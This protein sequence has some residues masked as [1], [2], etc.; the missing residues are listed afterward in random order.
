MSHPTI[1]VDAMGGDH[2]PAAVVRGA[3]AAV[4][5]GHLR[6]VLVG[7]AETLAA[8]LRRE[9]GAPADALSILNAADVV[10]M[11][12]SP[13]TALRRKPEASVRVA[14]DLVARGEADALFSA[15]HTGATLLA[16][17]AA[18][19]MLSGVERPALA[20]T[21]PTRTGAAVLLDAGANPDCRPHHLVQFALMGSAY[22]R[23]ALGVARPR[24]AL[25]STGEEA[26]KGNDLIRQAHAELT[27]AGV[28]FIGNIEAQAL[29]SGD[30]DVIVCDGFTG[31]I[32][33][34]VSEGLVALIHAM[35]GADAFGRSLARLD[36]AEAGGAPLLGVGEV[37][38]VGHGRSSPRAIESGILLAARLAD[39]HVVERLSEAL[40]S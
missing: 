24:V 40:G 13:L 28:A 10:A 23:V 9:G 39:E 27:G 14:A 21:L 8:E 30:A 7:P 36:Y 35:L 31:N 29:F 25:L 22:A 33:L 37:T 38:V 4:R 18:F 2:A 17:H 12:E 20:V 3:I 34:K 19:G 11:D 6:L 32:A 16:A 1:A 15:G 26:G 5:Q